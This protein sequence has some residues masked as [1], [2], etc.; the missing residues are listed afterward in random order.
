MRDVYDLLKIK[1]NADLGNKKL[2]GK[3]IRNIDDLD[4][5]FS[6]KPTD[7]RKINILINGG[8]G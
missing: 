3:T 8:D 7:H 6:K 2:I 5:K 1:N 4:D